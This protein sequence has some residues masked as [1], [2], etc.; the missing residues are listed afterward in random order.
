MRSAVRRGG[1]P[2]GAGGG[3]GQGEEDQRSRMEGA[4]ET[5]GETG[6]LEQRGGGGRGWRT[7]HC[8]NTQGF[9]CAVGGESFSTEKGTDL[10]GFNPARAYL[11]LR[12]IYGDF[13]HHNDGTQLAGVIPN[14]A[15]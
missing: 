11:S 3:G 9:I 13:P 4:P 8:S 10:Q 7:P 6:C 12:E 5:S 15:T 14:D 2:P 1:R